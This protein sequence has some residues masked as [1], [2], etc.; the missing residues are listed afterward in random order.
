VP[1][2]VDAVA[3]RVVAQF[4]AAHRVELIQAVPCQVAGRE[5]LIE[6]VLVH[7]VQN[8]IDASPADSPVFVQ[9]L[10]EGLNG[11]IEV[12][13]SGS[14]MSAEFIRTGLFKPFVSTKPGGFGIG[15]YEARELIVAMGGRLD[16]ESREGLGSRFTI[17]LPL[18]ETAELLKAF[19]N[20]DQK[21]A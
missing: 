18:A 19:T 16:V 21:V 9:V 7:L 11:V 6:Q 14:G 17:H 3:R 4:R 10:S 8:A 1:V 15:A 13:D 12:I 5:E 20:S 2:S